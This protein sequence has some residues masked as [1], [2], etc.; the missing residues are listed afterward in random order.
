MLTVDS[1]ARTSCDTISHY[2]YNIENRMTSISLVKMVS[3]RCVIPAAAAYV[4]NQEQLGSSTANLYVEQHMAIMPKSYFTSTLSY[5]RPGIYTQHFVPYY[6]YR[7]G[8][9]LY[10]MYTGI[11]LF[12]ITAGIVKAA[13]YR[14]HGSIPLLTNMASST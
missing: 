4:A 12:A 14:R 3:S 11:A 8:V 7:Q 9:L 6:I 2:L 10:C 13:Q 5:T 1:F